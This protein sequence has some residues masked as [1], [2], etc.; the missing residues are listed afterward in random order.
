MSRKRKDRKAH[1]KKRMKQRYNIDMTKHDRSLI[2][3]LIKSGDCVFIEENT[4]NC[5]VYDVPYKGIN[6]RIVYDDKLNQIVT[7]LPG[8]DSV[9]FRV[10]FINKDGKREFTEIEA[11][12]KIWAANKVMCLYNSKEVK[13]VTPLRPQ[14]RKE[15]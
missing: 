6:V 4:E 12:G 9:R 10:E 8:P 3:E 14:P 1:V 11:D 5:K 2:K 13:S 15:K 7:A